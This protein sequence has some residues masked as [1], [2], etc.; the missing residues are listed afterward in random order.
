MLTG[1]P[2][3]GKTITAQAIAQEYAKQ[4]F[5][6]LATSSLD[7][8]WGFFSH[9][10]NEKRLL[11][12]EDPFG[13]VQVTQSKLEQVRTLKKL[14]N[15]QTSAIRKL[16]VTTRKDILFTVF[17]K[18]TVSECSIGSCPWLDLSMVDSGFAQMIWCAVYGNTEE[19]MIC[20]DR[21]RT[22]INRLEHGIFLEIGEIWNLKSTYSNVQEIIP[23]KIEDILHTARISSEDVVEKIC[24][25]GESSIAVFLALGVAC[26]TIRKVSYQE[27]AY[28]LSDAEET[29]MLCPSKRGSR[30]VSL[31]FGE[32]REEAPTVYPAYAQPYSMS[33]KQSRIL[34]EFERY[35]Y[36]TIERQTKA[37]RFLHPIFC[38]AARLL[39]LRELEHTLECDQLFALGYRAIGA[40]NKNV[41]LC[42]VEILYG[43]LE[44]NCEYREQILN[45]LLRALDSRYPAIRDKALLRLETV[46]DELDTEQQKQMIRAVQDTKFDKYVLWQDGE[47]ICHPEDIIEV[48]PRRKTLSLTLDEINSIKTRSECSAEDMYY[49]LC[50]NLK[51]HLSTQLLN[52]AMDYDESFIREAAVCLLFENH[53]KELEIDQYLNEFED[54]GVVC[55]LFFGA[56]QVWPQYTDTARQRMLDYFTNQLQRVSVA[57]RA[58]AF[59]DKFARED[60][61]GF[62][63]DC[64]PVEEKQRVWE[65]WCIVYT[66][67]ML[68]LQVEFVWID[69]VHMDECMRTMFQYVHDPNI[70][71]PLFRAWSDWL[72]RTKEAS[73]YGMCL[74]DYVLQYLPS[75]DK[76]RQAFLRELLQTETTSLATSHMRYLT[77]GWDFLTAQERKFVKDTLLTPRE[78]QQWL[79]AI[80]LTREVVPAELQIL[81]LNETPTSAADWV[82]ALRRKG[83]LEP[84]LNIYCGYPQPLWWNG[85]HHA[86]KERWTSIIAEELKT[87]FELDGRAFKIA[88]RE[89]IYFEYEWNNCFEWCREEIWGS[90]L[91]EPQKRAAAFEELLRVT[92]TVCQTNQDVWTRYLGSCS[93]DELM[94]SF[95]AIAA[96][97]EAIEYNQGKKG[98]FDL[99][100]ASF[101]NEYL[102]EFL[103]VDRLL[104]HLCNDI[105]IFDSKNKKF[106]EKDFLELLDM[107]D[108]FGK[109]EATTLNFLRK[110]QV[111]MKS[112][113]NLIRIVMKALNRKSIELSHGLEQQRL[114]AIEL[115]HEQQKLFYDHYNLEKWRQ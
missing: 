3:C 26:N 108:L 53:V 104:M 46:F 21:I 48:R 23:Q 10:S 66:Q 43:C 61:T 34:I 62:C 75:E 73:D 101:V 47:A 6:V 111:H 113:H 19:S 107:D 18:R 12:L 115:A 80:V 71:K 11:L 15:E 89:F 84:C 54:C 52:I 5:E 87:G 8:G 31:S 63:W 41:G 17:N 39:F 74:T 100:S 96:V 94:Q 102:Y 44:L 85:Y 98:C 91:S 81:L 99:F 93:S 45:T 24:S 110:K 106:A 77:D 70:L 82:S 78:D 25:E 103:P 38:Y 16:I 92:T 60:Y 105:L 28:I 33:E 50:S 69:Q 1:L 27:L 97:I 4:G 86:S 59:L 109:F 20:F 32:K 29:P 90:L 30:G 88:L 65:T 40:I 14:I 68:H 67:F 64:F 42:A 56:L 9:R 2:F 22:H 7:E 49:I 37:I 36:I 83:L 13:A 51:G 57:I 95:K 112:T 79:Q 35:G 76:D 114:A 72:K 58:E 55:Q